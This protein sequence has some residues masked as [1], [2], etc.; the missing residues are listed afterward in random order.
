MRE[1]IYWILIFGVL[2]APLFTVFYWQ[3]GTHR[4]LD[5]SIRNKKANTSFEKLYKLFLIVVFGIQER[6]LTSVLCLVFL[7]IFNIIGV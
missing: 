2:W 3:Y 4:D 1:Y 6:W 5:K 7:F